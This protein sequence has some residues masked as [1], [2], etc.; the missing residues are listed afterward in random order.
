LLLLFQRS[1]LVQMLLPEAR[2]AGGAGLG[3][4]TKWTVKAVVGLGTFDSVTGATE[5]VQVQPE[6]SNAEVPAWTGGF[7]NFV[8]QITGT[9]TEDGVSWSVDG[10][11]PG[12]TNSA[13]TTPSIHLISGTPTEVGRTTVNITAWQKPNQTGFSF[14]QEFLII[15]DP[16][17]ITTQPASVVIA[18]GGNTIL[19]VAGNPAG[20]TLSYRWFQGTSGFGTEIAG[21]Q[22]NKSTLSISNLTT[23]TRYWVRVTQGGI[24]QNSNTATVT[25]ATAPAITTQPVS[26]SI[27]SGGSA[28]LS[29]GVSGTAPSIQWYRG[30]SGITT[31]PVAGA[32][33]AII[34]TPALAT[35]TSFWA[36][37]TNPAGFVNSNAA[38]V[39]VTADPFE[40]WRTAQFNS[41]QLANPAISGA[42]ADPDGDGMSNGDE[43]VFGTLPLNREPA[44]LA[45]TVTPGN[46]VSL[47]FTAKLASG[48]GYAGKTRRYALESRTGLVTGGWTPV[49]GFEDIAG[50]NQLVTHLAVGGAPRAFYRLRVWLSP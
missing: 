10:L 19:S 23:T 11:P 30:A 5:I 27:P 18:S 20:G 33:S 39:T 43:Y 22:G 14:S 21:T 4:L 2:V 35:T 50:N 25:V 13:T 36:R 7:L 42:T 29:V 12:L 28:Q 47:A 49:T 16:G 32:T 41:A 38:V 9:P 26:T 31:D 6:P 15:V 24:V 45:I 40:E 46:P 37:A 8:V 34:T 3:E 44:P 1:P 48:A 17:I